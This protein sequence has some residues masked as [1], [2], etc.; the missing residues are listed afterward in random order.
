MS[1]YRTSSAE[2]HSTI[3]VCMQ[4]ILNIKINTKNCANKKIKMVEIL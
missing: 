4:M 1:R 3:R 2:L